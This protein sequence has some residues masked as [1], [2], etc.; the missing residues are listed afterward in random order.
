MVRLKATH[1]G[2]GPVEAKT[3]YNEGWLFSILKG[4]FTK[5]EQTLVE[6]G[7]ENLVRQ[8]RL[9]FQEAMQD[10]FLD[11]VERITSRTVANYQSAIMVDPD[12]VVEIFLLEDSD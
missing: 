7:D 4:G 5:V 12:Y 8:V 11:A 3:F 9:R 2:K 10:R 6:S 1:Y